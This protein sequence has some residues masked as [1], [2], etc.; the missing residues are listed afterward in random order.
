MA[1]A[2]PCVLELD[3]L[4]SHI[5]R[6]RKEIVAR[7]ARTCQ[8]LK[9]REEVLLHDL[10]QLEADFRG[11]G[12]PEQI[13]ELNQLKGIQ[14]SK[15][16][17]NENRKTLRQTTAIL[18][19]RVREIEE[20]LEQ[21][22]VEMRGIALEWDGELEARIKK[23]GEIKVNPVP[24]Y[25]KKGDLIKVSCRHDA[26]KSA[27]AGVFCNPRAIVTDPLSGVVYICDGGNNRVQ[28]FSSSFDFLFEFVE[29]MNNPIGICIC[30]D[31]IFVT[32]NLGN[33][34]NE[35]T[36]EGTFL[37]S[38]GSYG[39]EDLEFAY[40]TGVA[41]S[42]EKNR[43]YVC[44]WGNNRIQCL[45][46]DLT[47]NSYISGIDCP[48]DAKLTSYQIVVLESAE[49]CIHYYDYAHHLITRLML[50]NNCKQLLTPQHFCLDLRNNILMTDS[51][52]SCV[53]IFSTS[54]DLAHKFGREGQGVGEFI[55][56]TGIALDSE[57]RIIIAS[58]NSESCIQLF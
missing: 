15:V 13:E 16:K 24:D 47:F 3:T 55:Q 39:S 51:S 20:T 4:L 40:P 27:A 25:K 29:K 36:D 49:H 33:C 30:K 2:K 43:I 12:V 5:G 18:D 17:R 37:K 23:L 54:G 26:G 38:V 53:F 8:L 48:L 32:Q 34:L 31:K 50:R 1:G 35:Y 46:M 42:K 45:A 41:A 22:R 9:E 28:V 52:A 44:D 56:P 10:M 19:A 6:V 7:F 11:E 21:N 57:N 14:I 58:L